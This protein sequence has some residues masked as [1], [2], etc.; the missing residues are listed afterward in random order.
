[1]KI[2]DAKGFLAAHPDI[3]R[4]IRECVRC[5]RKGYDTSMQIQMYPAEIQLGIKRF[6]RPV[7]IGPYGLC[8]DC[9]LI[10]HQPGQDHDAASLD[11]TEHSDVDE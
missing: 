10:V 4:W 1:M 8:D 2:R 9:D 11:S 5:H 7:G 6:L 3:R